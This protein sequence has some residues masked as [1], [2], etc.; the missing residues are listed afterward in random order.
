MSLWHERTAIGL[1]SA[2]KE[3]DTAILIDPQFA[4]A[5]A[6]L[7]LTWAVIY[8]YTP[9]LIKDTAP[10]AAAAAKRALALDP[11][12]VEAVAALASVATSKLRYEEST[13]LY[14][15]AIK[16]NPS[17]ATAYQWYGGMLSNMGDPETGVTMYRKAWSL[18]PRSRIIG[19]NLA[20][21]LFGLGQFDEAMQIA[22][23]VM[24]FAPE[25]PDIINTFFLFNIMNG[26][27]EDAKQYGDSLAGVLKK[28]INSTQT[29]LDLCQK[30]DRVRRTAAIET[31]LSWPEIDFANPDN[32]T[33]SYE[34]DLVSL[35]I[36][37]NEFDSV[38]TLIQRSNEKP[39]L[40]GWLRVHRTPSGT[41][42]QCEPRVKQLVEQVGL[43][44]VVQPF[45]CD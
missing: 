42:F 3:F 13:D 43:P 18:D 9:L 45:V 7:A 22:E 33:L 8:G 20:W 1:N 25:F 24:G 38:W 26:N 12:N 27:C 16:L 31:I 30:E 6:G 29:Y 32:P 4:K 23:Q 15:Q 39:C 37:V 2:F 28:T 36:E 19:Y 44:P 11:G 5:H 41:K 21:R 17:F 10:K 34:L 40:L 14:E 35:F